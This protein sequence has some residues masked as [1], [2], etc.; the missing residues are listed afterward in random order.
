M[1]VAHTESCFC[2]YSGYKRFAPNQ[3]VGLKAVG[4]VL[5]YE[6]HETDT[7]GNVTHIVAN[8]APL[9]DDNKPKVRDET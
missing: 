1:T 9:A 2:V 8:C 5:T 4:F 3:A 6:S 7:A